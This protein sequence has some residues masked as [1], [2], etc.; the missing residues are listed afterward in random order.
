MENIDNEYQKKEDWK[1][2]NTVLKTIS[3]NKD[4]TIEEVKNII[5]PIL[6]DSK[7]KI[8]DLKDD[9]DNTLAHLCI[10]DDKYEALVIITEVYIQ[11]IGSN[12][13]FF[14]WF[15]SKNNENLDVFD[16]SARRGNKNIIKF[17][18]EIII[19]TNESKLE[20]TS[21]RNNV[22]HNAALKNQCYPIIFFFE[23]LQHFFKQNLI[24]DIPNANGITPLHYACITGSKEV[25]DLLLDMGCNINAKDNEGNTC[26]HFG[27]TS[28]NERVVKKLLIRGADKT[29]RNNENKSPYDLAIEDNQNYIA[30]VLRSRTLFQKCFSQDIEITA[31]KGNRNN[32]LLLLFV[33]LLILGKVIFMSR[34]S[35]I[36]IPET[37]LNIE[38]L[39]PFL[40]DIVDENKKYSVS[41]L[42]TSI[43]LTYYGELKDAFKCI[44]SNCYIEITI[45]IISLIEDIGTLFLIVFFLCYAKKVLLKKKSRKEVPFL[46]V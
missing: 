46:S 32:I 42:D 18:Y 11:C 26:L 44:T 17:L 5:N 31:I 28:G 33:I 8:L 24:I 16:I 4:K 29:L 36:Y 12:S 38:S 15:L 2:I 9:N 14:D 10:S 30:N 20:L 45:T 19:K 41:G 35:F 13:E 40:P 25:M 21:R 34:I 6:K 23:H 7:H 37:N 43:N 1:L 22:F 3:S 39:M 27:V